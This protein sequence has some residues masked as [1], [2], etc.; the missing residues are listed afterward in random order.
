[1]KIQIINDYE[2]QG[3]VIEE[4]MFDEDKL[5]IHFTDQ[6]FIMFE[7]SDYE[8]YINMVNERLFENIYQIQP[9]KCYNLRNNKIINDEEFKILEE[10]YNQEKVLS[11][12]N[13]KKQE[14]KQLIKL[15]E[16]YPNV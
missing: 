3:K 14:I 2:L 7:S 12:E 8:T 11:K 4:V 13:L 1:M 9:Y 5:F 10:R 16:K 6:T 15:K